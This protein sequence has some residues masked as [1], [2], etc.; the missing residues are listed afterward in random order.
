MK[1][2]KDG[3]QAW[4]LAYPSTRKRCGQSAKVLAGAEQKRIDDAAGLP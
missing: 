2:D 3:Y 1:E 4:C